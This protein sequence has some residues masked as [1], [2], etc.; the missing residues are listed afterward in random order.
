MGFFICLETPTKGMYSRAEEIGFF[1]SPSGR[2][3]P[4]FQ[5]RTIRELLDKGKR[6]RLPSGLLPQE[7]VGQEARADREQ[8][9]LEM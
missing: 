6:L 8:G 9:K 2:K 3:I 7:R 4:K 1:D 5:I